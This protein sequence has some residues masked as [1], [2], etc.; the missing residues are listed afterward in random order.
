MRFST[1][2]LRASVVALAFCACGRSDARLFAN[3]AEYTAQNAPV[4]GAARSFEPKAGRDVLMTVGVTLDKQ[5]LARIANTFIDRMEAAMSAFPANDGGARQGVTK[6]AKQFIPAFLNDPFADAP[7]DVRAFADEVGL[8]NVKAGWAVLSIGNMEFQFTNGRPEPK[9]IPEMAVAVA[10]DID[11]EKVVAYARRKFAEDKTNDATIT[12]V[13]IAGERAWQIVPT[14]EEAKK[15]AAQ[16]KLDPCFTSLDGQLVLIASTKAALE[17]QIQLY[18]RGVDEGNLLREFK[19]GNGDLVCLGVKEFGAFVKKCL[20]DPEQQMMPLKSAIPNGDKIF[21]GLGDV[22]VNLSSKPDGN[23]S[24][25]L[26]VIAASAE[27]ADALRSLM[28]TFVMVGAAQLNQN[29]NVPKQ[30][31]SNIQRW[32][33]EGTGPVIEASHDDV[34][35]MAAGIATLSLQDDDA[36]EP[37]RAKPNPNRISTSEKDSIPSN[38]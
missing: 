24:F 27:D 6:E 15:K 2:F 4:R 23:V 8:R 19:P 1:R 16:I 29:P 31:V 12:D 37:V 36:A 22:T 32:K 18:R 25:S 5:R 14:T 10:A 30:F 20:P 11:L 28:K 13:Q 35:T 26:K 17:K 33:I 7:A 34:L 21:F 38:K 3:I 9:Y